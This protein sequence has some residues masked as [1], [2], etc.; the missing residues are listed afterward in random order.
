MP[1]GVDVPSS[2]RGCRSSRSQGL[3]RCGAQVTAGAFALP[4]LAGGTG[5][6]DS[7]IATSQGHWQGVSGAAAAGDGSR[8]DPVP[9]GTTCPCGPTDLPPTEGRISWRAVNSLARRWSAKM[10]HGC[11]RGSPPTIVVMRLSKNRSVC[12]G[13]NGRGD[14]TLVGGLIG[15][16]GRWSPGCAR[17]LPNHR[18]HPASS[19]GHQGVVRRDRHPGGC[20]HYQPPAQ[21]RG[22]SS[23]RAVGFPYRCRQR[24]FL[25]QDTGPADDTAFTG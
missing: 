11:R 1:G 15:R 8:T 12:Y 17:F 13:F 20:P 7:R 5:R 6:E 10:L 3:L 4:N 25:A 22:G 23:G 18:L 16:P 9:C 21:H 19:W 2:R 14:F 24:E